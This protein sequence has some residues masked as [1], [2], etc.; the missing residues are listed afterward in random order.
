MQPTKP[1]PFTNRN[2]CIDQ[3]YFG[4]VNILFDNWEEAVGNKYHL[5][6]PTISHPVQCEFV[7][8]HLFYFYEWEQFLHVGFISDFHS[9]ASMTELCGYG[10]NGVDVINQFH[11]DNR[12]NSQYDPKSLAA[13]Y[14]YKRI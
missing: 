14:I 13:L 1:L 11:H 5:V 4:Q 9:P 2:N 3:P 8:I 6:G 12:F 10:N 7:G